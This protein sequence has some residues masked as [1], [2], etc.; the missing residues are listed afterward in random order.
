MI[1]VGPSA[2]TRADGAAILNLVSELTEKFDVVKEGWN[3]FNILHTAASRV[4]GLDVGFVPAKAGFD[5]QGIL[6]AA[7]KGDIEFVYLLGAD[8]I[9]TTKLKHAFVVYQGHHGEAGAH[10]A[11]VILPGAA[12][13]DKKATYVNMEGRVQQAELAVF[14][15][16]DAKEDWKII[17]ELA[18]VLGES[19]AF[20][21]VSQVRLAMAKAVPALGQIDEIIA[22]PFKKSGKKGKI[23]DTPMKPFI[24]NFYMTD[25]ISR[26]S[27]TMAKCTE[28]FVVK[29]PKK[30]VA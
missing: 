16:G 17:A 30:D 28:E 12:Y 18:D 3:G 1:I 26:A 9:D 7:G 20:E 6:A 10:A 14:P 19:L 23:E 13:T 29:K 21:N 15:P 5:V 2:Y 24:S 25:V 8:E 27:P 4:G 11:D 22:S